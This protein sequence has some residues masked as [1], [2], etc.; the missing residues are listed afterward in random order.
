MKFLAFKTQ[1]CLFQGTWGY[2]VIIRMLLGC[3]RMYEKG[4]LALI[5]SRS[6]LIAE[7]PVLVVKAVFCA[8][9]RIVVFYDFNFF[10]FRFFGCR[11]RITERNHY[12]MKILARITWISNL[13]QIRLLE[14]KSLCLQLRKSSAV[15]LGCFWKHPNRS[16]FAIFWLIRVHLV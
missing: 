3:A 10:D 7:I 14:L 4:W 9:F 16:F 13:R 15:Y 1:P 2:T 6:T 5:P 11:L 12:W 8:T